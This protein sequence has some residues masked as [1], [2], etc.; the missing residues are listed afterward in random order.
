M[1]LDQL[2]CPFCKQKFFRD[3][4]Y[5]LLPRSKNHLCDKCIAKGLEENQ[6]KEPEPEEELGNKLFNPSQRK[7]SDR[8]IEELKDLIK[9]EYMKDKGREP[10]ESEMKMELKKWVWLSENRVDEYPS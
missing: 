5:S 9:E 3:L 10:T 1:N 2:E 4:N 6:Y 8:E 7:T